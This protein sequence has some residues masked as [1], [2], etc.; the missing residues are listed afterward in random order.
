MATYINDLRL[1]EISTGD[2]S[3]TWGTS[4]NTNLELIGEAL[5]Y[6]TQQ[7]FGSDADATTT[8][9]DGASDPA[10]AMYFKITSAGSLT[11]TR[12]CTIAPNTVSR[13]MFIENATSGSQSIAISQGSGANVTIATGKTAV[14]Y[15]DGAGSGAAV[16]DAMAGVD[17]G[18]TDTLAEVLTA[19]NTTTTDQKIQFRDAA[20]YIN[21]S[22]DGQLD[23]VADT[24]IQIAA[25]TVDVNGT[26][27]FDSLKGTGATTV[28]NILDEDNMASDSATA[29]ATQQSIKAYV[30][31]QVGSFDTLA[32]VLAQ[33]NTTGGTDIA[34]GTGDD[35]T[36][37][38]NS[39][40]I[41][42]AAS[43]LQIYHDGSNSY[44]KDDGTGDLRIWADSPNIATASGNKI[45]YGNAGSAELY[46]SGGTL[47]LAT[48]AT[49][50]DVTGTVTADG[51]TVDGNPVINGTS[52]QLF[53][54]T[55][56]SN[57]NW[58]IAAQENVANAF[59]ISSG[60]ADASA[61]D[62]TYTPRLVVDSSGNVIIGGTTAQAGDA[63]TLLPDGEVTAAGFYFSN[64]IGA[65][66][67]D[68]GIRKATTSTMV[69]DTAS[70]ER[71]RIEADGDVGIGTTGAVAFSAGSGLRIERAATATLRL[72]DTGAHGFEIRAAA[73]AAEFFSANS[74][75]FT[76]NGS[77]SE[78]MRIDSSGNV[79][80]GVVPEA[81]HASW[82]ALQIGP[83]G[84]VGS[85]QAGTTDI[86]ALGSNVYSDG[87]YKYIETDE[88]VIYKQQ[89]GTHI[90]DVAPSG[91]ANAAISWTTAMTIDNS[92][93]ILIGDS[94]SHTD[95]LLQI[96]TPAS[97][98][99]H[100]IQIRRNDS[101][102]DQGVGSITFG[103]NTATD[104]A[105]I[106]AKT[107]G[108]TDNGAL[109]FNTSVSGGTN[110]ERMRIDSS[111]NVGIGVTPSTFLLPNG[112]TG[113][114]QLQSGGLLSAYSGNTY[115]SQNWYYNAGE[116]YIAN[117]SASRY[118][119]TGAEHVW[120]SA[121]NNT[122]G[123]GAGISWQER[124]RIDASGRV[125]IGGVPNTNW[126]NDL[127][128]QEVLMLGT[129]ATLF[130]DG[131]ITTELFNNAYI[132]NSDT[133][134]NIS[135]R[136]ASRYQQ[137]Q[138]AHKW[139]TA[140]SAS[141]GSNINTELGITP[142]MTLDVSGNLLVGTTTSGDGVNYGVDGITTIKG[143]YGAMIKSTGGSGYEALSLWNT[144]TSGT[145]Y[146]AIFRDGASGAARGTITT[147]GSATA[148]NTTSDQR[149]KENIADADDAGSKIDA[150]QVRKFDWKADGSHQDYGMVAQELLEVA[151][152]AVSA[153]EDPEEMMGVDY[154]KLVPMMLKEIQSLRARIAA[155]ES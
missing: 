12:T 97:G 150:I 7:V 46:T 138:G 112:S 152:E 27:A 104:L 40:A 65:A 101:N 131:G 106:S 35:I 111:G 123:A 115:L 75:P 30:D 36:F 113:A 126:R 41:F 23:L 53:L 140:A 84:F 48:S 87:T 34:V 118:A 90:F 21:S 42:G 122:S 37:A 70:T 20:I 55:G 38:D 32:E 56:A 19:G 5:G 51:L 77:T 107:D 93:K 143:E 63:V 57:T 15:L 155:L 49:G 133:V 85:Y 16:V 119:Q 81:W 25:T 153:P 18:V 59:E 83:I 88:A 128:S 64:N 10:R 67:N 79:G 58:Q 47:R 124:M 127:A 17:P 100:G 73:G 108:A 102:T 52:P 43:D 72:Q 146:Q 11:A 154:S 39:K 91:T 132:N 95:D 98:G 3:G 6:A 99:G 117:G 96:E 71:M 139:W 86:T 28:T 92:G 82:K 145:I 24:E 61:P 4:T 74:K 142:K 45:F 1:K 9:A 69:F 151:P 144:A 129:E 13:V 50:I 60:A 76:F 110:T 31:S 22:A 62:D 26:L 78:L 116:K 105:S 94:A 2:E 135:T 8:V 54:Q 66:M 33:G 14:V 89:N 44:I 125:G 149:L 136:G 134:F 147:N 68:T 103:N 114:L 109:L 130:A 137:Y 148:Y 121:G 80:I 29:I 141:A 120:S